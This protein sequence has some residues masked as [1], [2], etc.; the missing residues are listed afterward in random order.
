M[1]SR[2]SRDAVHINR[3][4]RQAGLIAVREEMGREIARCAAPRRRSRSPIIRSRMSMCAIPSRIAVVETLIRG[5]DGRGAG[6]RR[7]TAS[8]QPGSTIRAP[9]SSSRSPTAD[10]WFSYYF[11]LDDD[12]APDY[13]RTVDIHR[14]PGY[15]PVELFLDPAIRF[16]PAFGRLAAGEAQ[17]RHAHAARRHLA[18]GHAAGEGLARPADRRSAEGPLVISSRPELMPDGSAGDAIQG[19]L[20][21]ARLRSDASS[22]PAHIALE[23]QRQRKAERARR[24]GR[25]CWPAISSASSKRDA[26]D[27]CHH[28]E[29]RHRRAAPPQQSATERAA[30]APKAKER[31]ALRLAKGDRHADS[32]R[33]QQDRRRPDIVRSGRR[34]RAWRR[35]SGRQCGREA[36][37]AP[38]QSG[39]RQMR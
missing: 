4:L 16:P 11:W 13:A 36:A 29:A 2:R 24:R 3:A 35:R 34:S 6:A 17:A 14:K 10:R 9:A 30:S 21:E 20:A 31:Q 15:D 22:S 38:I 5:L 27:Q 32:E 8:E 23:R 1:A 39:R 28:G 33:Q 7:R 26:G 37:L 18:Q 25:R 19:A 12:R